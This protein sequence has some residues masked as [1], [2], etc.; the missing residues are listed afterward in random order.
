MLILHSQSLHSLPSGELSVA[1]AEKDLLSRADVD[2]EIVEFAASGL[3][4]H[5]VGKQA[6]AAVNYLWSSQA[7]NFV[8]NRICA[9]K[10]DVVHFHGIFPY[11]SASA[12]AAAHNSGAAVVQTLHNGRWLC[13][14][15]GF[16]R[17]GRYCD[18]CVGQGGL[19]GVLHGCRHGVAASLLCHAANLS[20]LH[21]G[22][23]FRWVDRFIAVSDFIRD[24][25]V[26]AG[27]PPDK[28]VVKHNSVNVERLRAVF[29]TA[30]RS[31]I[32]YVSRISA[33]KGSNILKSVADGI[34]D[35]IHVVGDGPDLDGLR[36]YCEA[37]GHRHVR[38]WGKQP[39]ERCF[40][41]MASAVCT[42][43][44]S[45]CGESFSLVTAESMGLGTP[46]VASDIGGLGPLLRQA[47]GG[48]LVAPNSA[49]GF[50]GAVRR[51]LDQPELAAQIGSAGRRYVDEHLNA[52]RNASELIAIYESVLEE[53]RRYADHV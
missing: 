15:G 36:S 51:L 40:E 24:Q 3:L 39:Q 6:F 16:Y 2:A 13:L 37:A 44:P 48:L 18:D 53:K 38:F 23:L 41:I 43:V 10:P 12:L 30:H 52:D 29:G 46:V 34:K 4:T 21:G 42:L 33:A 9:T 47:G 8:A 19:G 22:R 45:Q 50:V 1:L 7:Y 32:A 49:S 27:F 26:R 28:I 11:L 31:G 14:E 17:D 25:H 5:I 20:A 35:E